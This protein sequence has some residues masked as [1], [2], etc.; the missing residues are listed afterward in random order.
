MS[1]LK[2]VSMWPVFINIFWC[3]RTWLSAVIKV[4]LCL[5]PSAACSVGFYK[6]KSSDAG[7]SKCPPHSHSLRDGATVCDCHSGFFRADGDPPSMACTRKNTHTH[8]HTHTHTDTQTHTSKTIHKWK[9][10]QYACALLANKSKKST[11]IVS[12][13][14]YLY[15]TEGDTNL[16]ECHSC[17]MIPLLMTKLPSTSC[18]RVIT[19]DIEKWINV[20]ALSLSLLL[21]VSLSLEVSE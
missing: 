18:L 14:L 7:C 21:Y 3:R 11:P 16:S 2:F 12:Q 1:F 10:R 8:T 9:H 6:A 4:S 5:C 15:Q 19:K 13:P 17:F 20:L